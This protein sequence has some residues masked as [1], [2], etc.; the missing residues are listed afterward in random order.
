VTPNAKAVDELVRR[1]REVASPRR[2]IL[3]GSVARGEAGPESDLDVLV[4]VASGNRRDITRRVYANLIG[5]DFPADVVVATEEDICLHA[6]NPGLIYR[7][8]VREGREVY[9]A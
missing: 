9:A 8:A 3:F 1:I 7:H 4:V 6:D 5:F 2:I